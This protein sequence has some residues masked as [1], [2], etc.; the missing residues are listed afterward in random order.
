MGTWEKL[1]IG[2]LALGLLFWFYPGV[3][4][5]TERSRQ[6]PS[7]WPAV[8]VALVFVLLVVAVLIALV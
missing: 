6:A 8:I 7:D 4:A 2:A 3:K 1:L 5:M